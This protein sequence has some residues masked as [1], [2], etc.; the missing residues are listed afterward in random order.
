MRGH[1]PQQPQPEA[2]ETAAFLMGVRVD[3][4]KFI[5]AAPQKRYQN[6]Q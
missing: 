2:S 1:G 5:E 3:P 4:Q 6:V